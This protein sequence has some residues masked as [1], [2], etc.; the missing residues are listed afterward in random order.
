MNWLFVSSNGNMTLEIIG[1][2]PF[3]PWNYRCISGNPNLS[4]A[5][6][7]DSRP[8][9]AVTM[10]F[11]KEYPNKDWNLKLISRNYNI[12]MN[13]IESHPEYPW[14][15]KD[16]SFNPNLTEEFINKH[17]NEDWNC[18]AISENSNITFE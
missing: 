9:L 18:S 3:L 8:E 13:D 5:L 11:I 14:N 7:T 16:I 1:L 17:L 2:N 15:Y 4:E 10:N 12:T 6:G